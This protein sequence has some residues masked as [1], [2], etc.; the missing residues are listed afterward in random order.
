M[1]D[2]GV[3]AGGCCYLLNAGET[4]YPEGFEGY[5]VMASYDQRRWFRVPTSFDG[6]VLEFFHV[7]RGDLVTYAYFA[8]YSLDRQQKLLRRVARGR[9]ARVEVLGHTPQGRPLSL[10]TVGEAS[11]GQRAIWVIA[12]QHPGETMAEWFAEG[13]LRRLVDEEDEL[14][15][16]LLERAVFHVVP[17]M[18]PDGG[19]LGNLRTNALGVDLN[20][21]W[22][23]PVPEGPE[24]ALVRE[25]MHREGVDLFLDIH[26]DERNPY[27]FLAGCEGNPGYSPRLAA[28]EA[29]FE[30]ALCASNADF[31]DEYKYPRDAPGE[32]D[33]SCASNYVGEVFDCLSFTLEMPFKDNASAPDEVAGWSPERS[34]HLGESTLESIAVAMEAI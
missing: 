16:T 11:E 19:Y 2:P 26:G 1:V 33:L 10:V 14:V 12:R 17:N 9:G 27:C 15:Q 23:F 25:R 34:M 32:G 31:Q 3:N 8:P 29:L 6:E 5:A 28:L 13:L 22:N 7:P 24:V 30:Q 21:T 4:T 20:R 18:N